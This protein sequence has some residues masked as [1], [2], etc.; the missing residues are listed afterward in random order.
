[1][2]RTPSARKAIRFLVRLFV[3][4]SGVSPS[5]MFTARHPCIRYAAGIR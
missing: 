3:Y 1:M 4:K 5:R 2:K